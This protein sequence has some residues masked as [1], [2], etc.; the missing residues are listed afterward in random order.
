MRT[1]VLLSICAAGATAT[2]DDPL[3]AWL[4]DLVLPLP[5]V[6]GVVD[7]INVTLTNAACTHAR[8]GGLE[9]TGRQ[10]TVAVN[11]T[12]SAL[13]CAFRWA[14]VRTTVPHLRGN[15]RA[16]ASILVTRAAAAVTLLPSRDA[17]PRPTSSTLR[18]CSA[19]ARVTALHVTG[20]LTGAL[21]EILG[22]YIKRKL[23]KSF[24]PALCRTLEPLVDANLTQLVAA[25]TVSAKACAAAAQERS[26]TDRSAAGAAARAELMDWRA[27]RYATALAS[28][29]A[30]LATCGALRGARVGLNVSRTFHTPLGAITVGVGDVALD[31]VSQVSMVPARN[32]SFALRASGDATLRTT[33]ELTITSP[34]SPAPLRE[35]FAASVAV[36]G[37]ALDATL[38]AAV[39]PTGNEPLGALVRTPLT[40]LARSVDAVALTD[41]QFAAETYASAELAPRDPARSP[42]AAGV[43]ATIDAALDIIVRSFPGVVDDAV[44]CALDALKA[45]VNDALVRR[46]GAARRAPCATHGEAGPLDWAA[47]PVLAALDGVD[48]AAANFAL[49]CLVDGRT[50]CLVDGRTASVGAANVTVGGLASITKLDLTGKGDEVE[51][52]LVM[53]G[54]ATILVSMDGKNASLAFKGLDVAAAFDVPLDARIAGATLNDGICAFIDALDGPPAI[55]AVAV[56]ASSALAV[57]GFD[58]RTNAALEGVG[59][60]LAYEVGDLWRGGGRASLNGRWAA[61][62]DAARG[63]CAGRAHKTKR[64]A[65]WVLLVGVVVLAVVFIVAVGLKVDDA[66]SRR[67]TIGVDATPLLPGLETDLELLTAPASLARTAPNPMKVLLPLGLLVTTGL[68]IWSHVAFA[69]TVKLEVRLLPHAGLPG[70]AEVLD[71]GNLYK[72]SLASSVRDM[73]QARV[74]VLAMLVL[75]CSGVWP[76]TKLILLGFCWFAPDVPETRRGHI[77]EW[78]DVLGKWALIDTF[79]MT[80]MLVAFHFDVTVG[81]VSGDARAA[82]LVDAVTVRVFVEALPSF[83]VYVLAS[84]LSLLLGHAC[85]AMHRN[86]SHDDLDDTPRA[87]CASYWFFGFAGLLALVV[88]GC[89]VASFDFHIEGLAGLVLGDKATQRYSLISLGT[90]VPA[91]SRDPRGAGALSLEVVYFFFGFALPLVQLVLLAVLYLTPLSLHYQRKLYVACEVATSWAALDVFAVGVV[92]ALLEIF[93]F[94][95]FMVG[96]RCDFINTFLGRHLDRALNGDDTCFDVSTELTR[97]AWVLLPAAAASGVGG[98]WLLRRAK[99]ALDA[100]VEHARAKDEASSSGD[101]EIDSDSNADGDGDSL[102]L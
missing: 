93:K 80:L 77:L 57:R 1:I 47:S 39:V 96:D 52:A 88:Y 55:D 42:L 72:F 62:L 48:P 61:Q 74:Y 49:A 34:L 78:V 14:Y 19:T 18:N 94:A 53:Q 69:A 12:N 23:S 101:S 79:V 45:K 66:V 99:T 100:R 71:L 6:T 91:S 15:G 64:K 82:A 40:C 38:R 31:G 41:A 98:V 86:T 22:P 46:L 97:G 3:S 30:R 17:R 60:A 76:Y 73:W 35:A 25:T 59:R 11:A 56:R 44:A 32:A 87:L 5:D 20:G 67:R 65:P 43:D 75:L 51:A 95:Q 58:A 2:A 29:A 24:G 63:R 85:V 16:S 92:A 4:Y 70:G 36:R 37:A 90:A 68:F 8:I 21:L 13:D 83:F 28:V 89:S 50:A 84:C 7:T 33:L 26:A 9:A 81:D 10:A 27:S 54:P 102:S